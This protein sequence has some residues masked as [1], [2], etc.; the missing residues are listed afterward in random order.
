M[1][2][3]T[4]LFGQSS[5]RGSYSRKGPDVA[6][7]R[8]GD[9]ERGGRRC[10]AGRARRR[11]AQAAKSGAARYRDRDRAY[12]GQPWEHMRFE[13]AKQG[14]ATHDGSS[15]AVSGQTGG[16]ARQVVGQGVKNDGRW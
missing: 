13:E 7:G 8:R 2:R 11:E 1:S 15:G 14:W 5:G 12:D 10:V 6:R 9:G 4:I 3:L 16:K